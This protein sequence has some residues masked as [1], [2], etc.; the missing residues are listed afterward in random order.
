MCESSTAGGRADNKENEEDKEID[1][2]ECEN[3]NEHYT[4]CEK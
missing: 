4:L 3:K 2:N 1:E